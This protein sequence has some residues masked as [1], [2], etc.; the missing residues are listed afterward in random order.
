MAMRLQQIAAQQRDEE[1]EILQTRVVSNQEVFQQK[2]LW[3]DAIK[4]EMKSLFDK[5]TVRKLTQEE[6]A[7]YKREHADK[8]EVVPGKAVHTVKAPDG[9]RKCRLVVCGR[10]VQSGGRDLTKM[11][12][13][14]LYAGGADSISLRVGLSM[15][16]RRRWDVALTS[17]PHS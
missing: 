12:S 11:Q 10:H 1:D 13:A 7:Y 4:K 5:G 6:V 14:N 3:T 15:A 17:R 16:A 2:E 8:L 9:R